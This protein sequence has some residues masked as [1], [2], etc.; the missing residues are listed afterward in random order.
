[1][2]QTKRRVYIGIMIVGAMALAVDRFALSGATVVALETTGQVHTPTAGVATLTAGAATQVALESPTSLPIPEIP[3][4]RGVKDYASV[5]PVRDLFARV[6]VSGAIVDVTPDKD[7]TVSASSKRPMVLSSAVFAERRR[8]NAIV[9]V[10][11]LKIA[12]V[13]GNWVRV[14]QVI[15][16]C[17]L[18][19][20]SGTQARFVCHDGDAV[21]IVDTPRVLKPG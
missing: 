8:L 13:D 17:E 16:G 11:R 19:S 14:G 9:M 21:L 20:V 10:Q 18:R 4:P 3:F 7:G 5:L 1:M 2:S 12:V 6:S 15:D